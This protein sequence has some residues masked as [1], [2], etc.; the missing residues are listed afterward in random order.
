MI[1]FVFPNIDQLI[2]KYH[3]KQVSSPQI[4]H[5]EHLPDS[6]FSEDVFGPLGSEERFERF[7]YIDL[8]GEYV[9]PALFDIIKKSSKLVYQGLLGIKPLRLVDKRLVVNET[10]GLSGIDLFKLILDNYQSIQ[11][12]NPRIKALIEKYKD[13]CIISKILVIPPAYRPIHYVNGRPV[14]DPINELYSK[15]ISYT[16]FAS[17]LNFPLIQETIWNLYEKFKSLISKKS[18]LIRGQ[19]LGKRVDFSARGVI[20]SDPDLPS[21]TLGV[22]YVMLAQIAMPFVV[23]QLRTGFSDKYRKPFKQILEEEQIPVTTNAL[24][25][26]LVKFSNNLVTSQKLIDIIKEAIEQA[27]SDK[28][29]LA[30]RDPALHQ[31]SW[32]AFK[33]VPVE[34]YAIHMSHGYLSAFGGDFDGDSVADCNVT[35]YMKKNNRWYKCDTRIEDV[36]NLTEEDFTEA[37]L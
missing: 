25:T 13:N 17:N 1:K 3:L 32:E 31:Y 22:P 14:P 36:I 9:H 12:L 28:L 29:V 33:V 7:G 15:I 34:G 21:D 8:N 35:L 2:Q 5:S 18:G 24:Q 16:K 6:L 23:Y 4:L 11:N 26:L 30:K 27:V 37:C 10:D 20:I 19:I